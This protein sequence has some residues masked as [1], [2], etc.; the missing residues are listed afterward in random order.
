MREAEI[1]TKSKEIG[2]SLPTKMDEL[3]A[4]AA[5]YLSLRSNATT[6]EDL[7]VFDRRADEAIIAM[8]KKLLAAQPEVKVF[9]LDV[10]SRMTQ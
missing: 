2:E 3:L 7:A 10:V 5:K 8:R 1:L 9:F 6:E 4:A